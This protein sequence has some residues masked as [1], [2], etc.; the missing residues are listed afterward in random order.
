MTADTDEKPFSLRKHLI[1]GAF[2]SLFL[3][4]FQTAIGLLLAIVLARVL[5]VEGY[6]IYAFCMTVV[7]LITVPAMLGGQT[8]LIREV[9]SYR[10][11]GELNYLLGLLKHIRWSTTDRKSV[12]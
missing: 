3:R 5:G 2:G 7:N 12:G 1:Q 9:A 10:T 11:K 8:F 4:V 6:G